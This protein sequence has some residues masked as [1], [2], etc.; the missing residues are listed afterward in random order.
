MMLHSSF[1]FCSYCS[2]Q[3]KDIFLPC[4][5]TSKSSCSYYIMMMMMISY[6]RCYFCNPMPNKCDIVL[7]PLKPSTNANGTASTTTTITAAVTPVACS[8][9]I[10]DLRRISRR[11]QV[12]EDALLLSSDEKWHLIQKKLYSAQKN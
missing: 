9:S 10:V 2:R 5:A 11:I 4:H 1:I 7:V 8:R 3:K 6:Y 12:R